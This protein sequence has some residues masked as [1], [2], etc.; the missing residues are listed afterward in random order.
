MKCK[1]G[2]TLT[3]KR[4]FVLTIWLLFIGLV[5]C[6]QRGEAA[7]PESPYVTLSPDQNAFT[8][9][10]GEQDYEWYDYGYTVYT[11]KT[12][13]LRQLH[14]GEHY[15]SAIR[16]ETVPVGKWVVTHR[17]AK[18][19]HDR[20][21][22]AALFHG[23]SF[24]TSK[25][26]Q[27]Y[28][29]GW[30]PYCAD[31]G[32]P[33]MN[34]HVYMSC[35]AAATLTELDMSM[36][37]YYKCPWCD[38]LEM[39]VELEQHVCKDISANQY[40]VRYHAN[41]GKGYMPKSVHMYDNAESYEG[42]AVTPQTHLTLNSF[43][44][45]GYEFVGWNTMQDGSGTYY[46]DGAE[47][48]NLCEEE[49]GS[50]ILYAQWKKSQSVLYLDPAGGKYDGDPEVTQISGLYG[51]TFEV[52]EELIE[53]PAGA[54][55]SFDT[56]G[57][58]SLAPITG[59]QA[60][61]DWQMKT[62]VQGKFEN[63][64][65]TFLGK[66]GAEDYLTAVYKKLPVILPEPVKEGY[67]F[68]GWYYD[69]EG[70]KLAGAA[71]ESFIPSEDVTLYAAWVELQLTAVDNYQA[72]G[73]R[74]AVDLAWKQQ[75]SKDKTYLV[76]QRREG[77]EWQKIHS[78]QDI[79]SDKLIRRQIEF[80]GGQESYLVPY[81]GFYQ[82]T[83]SG[84]QGADYETHRGGKGGQVKAVLYLEQGD[85]LTLYAGGQN[86]YPTG[87]KGT[88]Y[89]NGGGY[90]GV[91]D[92]SG[93][94]LLIA[95]GGGGGS[96]EKDGLA[97]GSALYTVTDNAG[98]D[99]DA[100]GGGGY[101]GGS[102]GTVTYHVH[103]EEC[104]HVHVGSPDTYG[105]C[106]TVAELCGGTGFTKTKYRETF[107]Y[108]NIADD[109]SHIFC[110]RCGSEEC[111]GHRD[112]YYSYTCTICG[113]IYYNTQPARCTAGVKYGLGCD[114]TEDAV[115]GYEDGQLVINIAAAGGGNYVKEERCLTYEEAQGMNEGNGWI[116]I[117]AVSV[118]FLAENT[119]NGVAAP[120][121]A[122]PDKVS[123]ASVKYKAVDE[124]LVNIYFEK[125]EDRGTVYY[126]K[127]ESYVT[128]DSQR[129]CES[130]VTKNELVS[131]VVG[132]RYCVDDQGDRQITEEDTLYTDSGNAP[133]ISVEI[134]DTVQYL[135]VAAVDKA[136]NLS[137][138]AHIPIA[139]QEI[140]WWPVVTEPMFLEEGDNVYSFS[141]SDDFLVGGIENC[142]YVKA[143]GTT[144]F[145]AVFEGRICGEA[146]PEYQINQLYFL[147]LDLQGEKT[148]SD[149]VTDFDQEINSGTTET[150]GFS[151][152]K[153]T[154]HIPME[155]TVSAGSRIYQSEETDRQYN[156]TFCVT[157]A[158]YTQ[159]RRSD[160]C[161]QVQIIQS[162]SIPQALDGH[163]ICLIPGAGIVTESVQVTSDRQQDL[164]NGICLIA[165]GKGPGISGLD[166]E[167]SLLAE[168]NWELPLTVA[169]VDEGSG[170]GEL[171]LE[172][173][174]LDNG[175]Y[176]RLS[177]EDGDGRLEVLMSSENSLFWGAFFLVVYAV[178]RVG[179][180]SA[181]TYGIDGI[182][183]YAYLEKTFDDGSENFKKGESGELYIQS[184][185]YAE[186]VEVIFPEEWTILEPDLNRVFVYDGQDYLQFE[187]VSFMVPLG[188]ADGTY[189]ILVK[190]YKEG[191]SASA[192]PSLLTFGVKDSILGE[193]RT[194]LR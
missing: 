50:V 99:G 126:H 185:G 42:A 131:G 49:Q 62:P 72:N 91:F 148:G 36:G 41:F 21:T 149:I 3:G 160:Y 158:S 137:Q 70:T 102:A 63:S 153:L 37:Y 186:R 95:G 192:R 144:P 127:V 19:I 139:R 8:T 133:Y 178:D 108:G 98:E 43:T 61:A 97:G 184:T 84:A 28:F 93:N 140:T 46:E 77:D 83:V 152:G 51:S 96:A 9:N 105:G 159:V 179:N 151:E 6:S 75:D 110:V 45:V 69:R 138:T 48:L 150:N 122:A 54:K 132:Y 194:R 82:V 176:E 25:C 86:G 187:K 60:L 7:V 156:G 71:G 174:N 29:S 142:Y 118:G 109:G 5:L 89:G 15:Y 154:I 35:Q 104:E 33:V 94:A 119:L 64:I 79:I 18:C 183:V 17:P 11:G 167:E 66:D 2:Y 162:F 34:T 80:T 182:N 173:R 146:Q 26:L 107:Y 130:N 56:A 168:E 38:N 121:L 191:Y 114:R 169:A 10:A 171:R 145:T 115:C 59:Q 40:S 124:N 92:A 14:V 73:G 172:I 116:L 180:T 134:V 12:S 53:A 87:G 190:A 120:D 68:G 85:R 181:L 101:P 24:G 143:D 67:S 163:R 31:C 177:D 111:P 175:G 13:T 147:A 1:N 30:I 155:S 123:E 27:P 76:Y 100:G 88:V 22:T 55:V 170:L 39:G 4:C 125:P 23:V 74:G 112:S 135:H 103:T 78:A 58:E 57:G 20:Y 47:I 136:G 166:I 44:R 52:Q 32:D 141:P 81:S 128:A 65:Y 161:K 16:R 106:Y 165:D 90:S 117:E 164:G 189:S 188:V 157:D 193:L 129:L 113:K